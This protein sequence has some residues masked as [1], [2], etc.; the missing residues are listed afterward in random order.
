M[1]AKKRTRGF[2]AGTACSAVA[3]LQDQA[4]RWLDQGMDQ[5]FIGAAP[6][7]VAGIVTA[8]MQWHHF[9]QSYAG[10]RAAHP[11]T[12]IVSG[13]IRSCGCGA[14]DCQA[15]QHQGK[16]PGLNPALFRTHTR[17]QMHS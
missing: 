4:D 15:D 7:R 13:T 11:R 16:V 17:L 3:S 14:R 1:P 9:M 6:A 2:P 10:C 5:T 12:A 8:A